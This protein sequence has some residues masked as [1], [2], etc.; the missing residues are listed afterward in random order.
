MV[1]MRFREVGFYRSLL[2][3]FSSSGADMASAN[4][5]ALFR[6]VLDALLP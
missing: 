4:L 1:G 5:V 3:P 6:V 2:S